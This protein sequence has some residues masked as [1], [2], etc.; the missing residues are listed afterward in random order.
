MNLF[1]TLQD[2]A[3]SIVSNTMGYTAT[4]QPSVGEIHTAEILFNDATKT[5][6]LLDQEYSPKNCMI[7]YKSD[8]FTG[9]K[10]SADAGNE[11][12]V[13]INGIQYGVLDVNSKFDGKTMLAHLTLV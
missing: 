1:D 3:F 11:E 6:K 9:L 4:W 13:T 8:D 2:T 7:E 5:A 12:I 10:E